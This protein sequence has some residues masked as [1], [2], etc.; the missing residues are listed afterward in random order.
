MLPPSSKILTAGTSLLHVPLQKKPRGRICT[1]YSHRVQLGLQTPGLSHRYLGRKHAEPHS[2]FVCQA[3]AV[4]DTPETAQ[5]S[6]PEAHSSPAIV[7][8]VSGMKCGGCSAAVK[9]M[10]LQQ[11]GVASAAVN[12]LTGTAAIQ[13][14]G[15][16][17][18]QA[19]EVA[20]EAATS[21]TTKGFPAV[22]R[23]EEETE[24]HMQNLAAQKE[25]ELQEK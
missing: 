14:A 9:R 7:L 16:A 18:D 17:L 11:P 19:E 25:L 10:L 2:P 13:V 3:V 20:K 5:T 12:L 15:E 23:T 22:L 6:V 1:E 4:S 24:S 21:L 8:D